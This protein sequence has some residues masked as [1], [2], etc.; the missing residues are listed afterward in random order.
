MERKDKRICALTMVR[1]D[2]LYLRRWV[3]Y[4]GAQLG[5]DNLYVLFDGEDQIVPPFCEGV[6]T[7]V[8]P[9]TVGKIPAA[10]KGRMAKINAK[11]ANLFGSYDVVIGTDV[12]E[13]LIPD[14]ETGLSLR[15]FIES[16]NGCRV[17]ISGLGVDVG[18]KLGQ[19]QPIDWERPF[20]CQRHSAK[21]STRY[22]KPSVLLQP[23]RWGSGFHRVKGH[24]FHIVKDLY[25]FHF[26]CVDFDL[27]KS[28]M[29]DRDKLQSGWSRHLRKRAGTIRLVTSRKA[30]SWEC[31]V[32]V[33]RAVQNLVRPPYA[34]NKPS[35]FELK[36]VVR[37]P[38]R[39]ENIV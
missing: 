38:E 17:S 4:Y 33:A 34:L 30:R 20:L 25:L 32:P 29:G 12:D 7:E 31:T 26:G 13:F 11:A 39:F 37:I 24:D 21:L 36:V 27:L 18:Q 3:D 1:G 35:M 28:K 2:E 6:N 22:S 10:D 8:C 15:E 5:R 19:E 16:Y 9:R 23:C 14:P